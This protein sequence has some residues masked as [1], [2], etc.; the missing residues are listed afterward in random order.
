MSWVHKE[1]NIVEHE[2]KFRVYDVG[3]FGEDG[4]KEYVFLN[5]C[6]DRGVAERYVSGLMVE[7][8][9]VKRMK[10]KKK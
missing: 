6:Y 5:D 9:M 10:G 1:Y 3:Y 2:G 7:Q 8:E 4:G